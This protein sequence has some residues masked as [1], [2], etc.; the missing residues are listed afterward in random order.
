[1]KR[2]TWTK[3]ETLAQLSGV[4]N[5]VKA[6]K[7]IVLLG[8]ALEKKVYSSNSLRGA[9]DK[10]INSND[11]TETSKTKMINTW[12]KIKDILET[13]LNKAGLT[14]SFNSSIT[15]FTLKNVYGWKDKV[16]LETTNYN[17]EISKILDSINGGEV[18]KPDNNKAI[19]KP[20]NTIK[21]LNNTKNK[22]IKKQLTG[23]KQVLDI[24]R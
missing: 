20:D 18:V 16:D 19:N 3:K 12:A 5:T 8:E 13:R 9:I 15:Q 24:Y 11:I 4:L 1:M 21:S 7:D 14:N 17:I 22:T 23:V 10:W 2:I 6:N